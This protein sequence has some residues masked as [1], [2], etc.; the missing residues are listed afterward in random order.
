M[1]HLKRYVFDI[2]HTFIKIAKNSNV[3]RKFKVETRIGPKNIT[4]GKIVHIS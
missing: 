3:L 1:I 4:I 2:F